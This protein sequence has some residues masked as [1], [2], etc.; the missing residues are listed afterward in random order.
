MNILILEDEVPAA[1]QMVQFLAQAGLGQ[2]EP[3]VL[4]SI[5]KALA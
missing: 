4:R 5:E 3:P 2:P 1:R